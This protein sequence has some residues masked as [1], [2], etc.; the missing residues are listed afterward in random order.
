MGMEQCQTKNGLFY[1]KHSTE[2]AYFVCNSFLIPTRSM[3]TSVCLQGKKKPWPGWSG[4]L[5]KR[6]NGKLS[7]GAWSTRIVAA[8]SVGDWNGWCD[9][10]TRAIP[11]REI[12]YFNGTAFLHEVIV[13]HE[14]D[15]VLFK[16]WIFCLWLI[17]S[18]SQWGAGSTALHESHP[19]GWVDIVLSHIWL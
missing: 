15:A 12:I 3:G 13:D 7:A 2:A 5:K 16:S 6:E 14:C 4:V 1:K 9:I 19:Y 10:K 11:C 8:W 18:Q 17:Q